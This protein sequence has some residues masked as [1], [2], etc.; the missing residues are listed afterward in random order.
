MYD[1]KSN[2]EN[3]YTKLLNS[4]IEENSDF[5]SNKEKIVNFKSIS[6]N[7]RVGKTI[8]RTKMNT[9]NDRKVLVISK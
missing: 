5:S 2:K 8:L 1:F 4:S 6:S 3:R 9:D 7:Y